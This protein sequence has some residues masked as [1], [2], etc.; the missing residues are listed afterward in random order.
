LSYVTFVNSI[1]EA[2]VASVPGDFPG[3]D[4]ILLYLTL[5]VVLFVVI[6]MIASR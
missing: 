4:S 3:L 2:L 1:S 6:Y 5:S